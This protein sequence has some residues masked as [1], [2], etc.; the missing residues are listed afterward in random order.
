MEGAVINII[1]LGSICNGNSNFNNARIKSTGL[2]VFV[3]NGNK[4]RLY[5]NRETNS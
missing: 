2:V 5:I 3:A 1:S 4:E